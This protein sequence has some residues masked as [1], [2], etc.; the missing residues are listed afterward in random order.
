MTIRDEQFDVAAA[1]FEV[2]V[3]GVIL[4]LTHV[5]AYVKEFALSLGQGVHELASEHLVGATLAR[6]DLPSVVVAEADVVGDFEASL[7]S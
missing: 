4:V 2:V 1:R 7:E 6:H 5:V 3:D